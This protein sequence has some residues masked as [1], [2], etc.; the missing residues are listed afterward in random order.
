[1]K[2]FKKILRSTLIS[3]VVY[4]CISLTLIIIDGKD[5]ESNIENNE[6]DFVELI[7][8]YRNIPKLSKYN[9]RD[10]TTLYYRYYEAD[11][12]NVLILLHGSGWHSKYF[13]PLAIDISKNNNAHVY[14]LDLRGHGV[15]PDTRGDIKYISQYEDD[16]NDFI[17]LIKKLHPGSKIILG[18][19]SSGG[20]LAVRYGGS[21]YRNDIHAYLL[22]SPY[23][24]YNAP[25]MIKNSGGW[26]S[27][28][29]P[30][31]IGLTMLNNLGITLLNNMEIIDFN[32]PIKYR[33]GT[34]TLTYSYRLNTG[35]AP[36][37][38]K[39]DL[40][41]IKQE[42]Y[43]IVGSSDESFKAEMFYPEVSKYK[44]DVNVDI[45]KHITHMGVVT[46]KESSI[47][48]NKW[49]MKL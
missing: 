6:L 21:K 41:L 44:P 23:L 11:S 43:L 49:L 10:N 40:S 45:L 28:H 29:L 18:G 48:I 30:R 2:V 14:T 7:T 19:H 4:L 25:T 35:F 31:I 17:V 24:K 1:M 13:Y 42:V 8:D 15:Y 33:D 47:A 22:M 12:N 27:I 5:K 46:S 34:E 9:A 32:M 39:K 38:Y 26:T 36:K 20:G 3:I 16:I 37:N